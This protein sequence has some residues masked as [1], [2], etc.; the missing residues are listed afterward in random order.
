MKIR[1]STLEG[2]YIQNITETKLKID[3]GIQFDLKL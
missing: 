2:D 1:V 3:T